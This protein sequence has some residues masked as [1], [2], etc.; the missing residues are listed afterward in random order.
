[1]R[2]IQ[3]QWFFFEIERD[4]VTVV[5][6]NVG[7]RSVRAVL[8]PA[9]V[10]GMGEELADKISSPTPHK[11]KVWLKCVSLLMLTRRKFACRHRYSVT[12]PKVRSS[13][14]SRG[15]QGQCAGWAETGGFAF[16]IR[17]GPSSCYSTLSAHE[18]NA[19]GLASCHVSA[20]CI[21][22]YC[23]P[24]YIISLFILVF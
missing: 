2:F 18:P 19:Q 13:L 14:C 20:L 11:V 7:L 23:G 22:N 5:V 8:Y 16:V 21:C 10:T 12:L 1:M 6:Y 17:Y 3:S 24:L 4:S 9:L 15:A